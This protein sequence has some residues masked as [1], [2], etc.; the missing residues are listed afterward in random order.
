MVTGHHE[1]Y[2]EA[3]HAMTNNNGLKVPCRLLA[4]L[5]QC[6]ALRD[7]EFK[8]FSG[9]S[10]LSGPRSQKRQGPVYTGRALSSQGMMAVGS[11]RD[12]EN[13]YSPCRMTTGTQKNPTFE[14]GHWPMN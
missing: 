5:P 7:N 12:E 14:R 8:H 10:Q 13:R 11:E 3:A 4:S 1:T 9:F 2:L 6:R